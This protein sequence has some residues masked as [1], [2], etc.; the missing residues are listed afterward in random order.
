MSMQ[1]R[2]YVISACSEGTSEVVSLDNG[3]LIGAIVQGSRGAGE[4]D[5]GASG[6]LP[7]PILILML[8]LILS[9]SLNLILYLIL[10]PIPLP[11]P[12][13]AS[14]LGGSVFT[15]A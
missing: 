11:T 2:A 8:S 13:L 1:L 10:P 15:L 9:P 12:I 5:L 3:T 14:S 6:P 7:S 4:S